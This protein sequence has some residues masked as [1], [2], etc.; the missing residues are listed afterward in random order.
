M[1]RKRS[2]KQRRKNVIN[3]NKIPASLRITRKARLMSSRYVILYDDQK[4]LSHS[5]V[6]VFSEYFEAKSGSPKA[7]CIGKDAAK[8]IADYYPRTWYDFVLS[9]TS[10]LYVY[11]ISQHE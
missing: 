10:A 1:L 2:E 3:S 7:N 5:A 6:M 9:L 4:Y 8:G 11:F